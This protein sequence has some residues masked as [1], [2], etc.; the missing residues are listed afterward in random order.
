MADGQANRLDQLKARIPGVFRAFGNFALFAVKRFYA[1][2]MGMAA[3]ALTY[4]T[5]LALVPLMVLTF[6]ILSGFSAFD[7]VRLRMEAMFFDIFVPEVGVEVESY[8]SEF[9]RNATNLTAVGVV[10]LA[11][12]AVMLLSTIEFTLNRIWRVER[13]RPMGVR[14]LIFWT[15][16]TLGPLLLGASFAASS[17]TLTRV[18]TWAEQGVSSVPIGVS[19]SVL[20]TV[21]AIV[22]QAAAFTLLFI[23]VPARPV[24]LRDAAIGGAI[25]GVGFQVLRWWFN[26][27][28]TSGSTYETIYGAVAVIPIFLF[29]VYA[30]WTV[31]LFGAVFAASF[32]DWW[33]S[34]DA[35]PVQALSPAQRLEVAVALL[36]VLAGQARHGGSVSEA[37]L[38]EAAPLEG[39]DDVIEALLREGYAVTTEDDCLSLARDLHVTTVEDLARDFGLALGRAAGGDDGADANAMSDVSEAA[40]GLPALLDRLGEAERGIL[41]QPIW[42]ILPAANDREPVV[43]MTPARGAPVRKAR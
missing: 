5:L 27:F 3:A 15:I 40:G 2:G 10:A 39:R 38:Q 17:D 28:L 25:A 21:V 20:N 22:A 11:V 8:L 23:L 24:R 1:D 14:L 16:L 35:V 30:S 36:G 12:T 32:P 7:T 31:I 18:V 33:K 42:D 6:A 26:S 9:S 43:P 13:P 41:E 34:R 4:S 19:T 29:W 37:R